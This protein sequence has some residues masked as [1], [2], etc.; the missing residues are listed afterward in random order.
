[1]IFLHLAV[2]YVRF[3][4]QF[5]LVDASRAAA[6]IDLKGDSACDASRLV[7]D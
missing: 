7:S 5:S 1:M 4:P 2:Y 6:P 3:E